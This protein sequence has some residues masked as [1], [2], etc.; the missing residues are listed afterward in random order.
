M[1]LQEM[2][3]K[4]WN[5]L[6]SQS[7]ERCYSVDKEACVYDD[8]KGK[9]CAWGWV[10]EESWTYGQRGVVD[11]NTTITTS[12]SFDKLRFAQNLQQAHDKGANPENVVLRLRELAADYGLTVPE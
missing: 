8:G 4:A 12:L 2:F 11:I 6:K 10:D 3:D 7:F 5:G 1:T 9:H